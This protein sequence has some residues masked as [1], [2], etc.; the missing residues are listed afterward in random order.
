MLSPPSFSSVV[1]ATGLVFGDIG[2]SPI[3]TLSVLFLLV[4]PTPVHIFGTV[5][6]IF[7]TLIIIV[8]L[9]YAFLAM[10]LSLKGE[11]G[12]IVLKEIL[13]PMVKSRPGMAVATFLTFAGVSLMIGD[14]VIT[15]AISILS[16]V[17]GIRLIPGGEGI[18]S[19]LLILLAIAITLS[20]FYIQKKGTDKVA[21]T[22]GPVMVLWFTSLAVFGLISILR[23]PVILSAVNP[24]Y[25]LLFVQENPFHAFLSLS[26]I[27]LC[28]TG[29]EA[30]FA[31]MGH[32]GREPIRWSWIL[33]LG[34]LAI[35]YLG[36]GAFLLRSGPAANPFFSMIISEISYFY[37]PFLVLTILAT[38]IASQAVISG[39]FSVVYQAINIRL[40]PR[41]PIQY[42]S[43][44]LRTQ[45]YI[46]AVNW[47]LC[48]AV[49]FMLLVFGSSERLASVYGIA[50]CASMTI[51]AIMMT[52]I[53]Y[54]KR[55][56][57]LT[58]LS[59]LVMAVDLVFFL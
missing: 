33:V 36:Q 50:V 34:A 25:I 3:Y 38:I 45:V 12:V 43:S 52:A 5:S 31:D 48:I 19:F 23:Y 44:E 20:L 27:I 15:P 58:I 16:A 11:G 29:G 21:I 24:V 1:K 47:G 53:F 22:F 51:T 49:I 41:I 55:R 46:N 30:L 57:I 37:L 56:V 42:T 6:M 26:L 14:C 8:T 18:D 13:S 10:S 9:Q 2:T 40:L 54:L 35:V 39:I 17:E 28:A 32:L 59:V 7:W 4:T